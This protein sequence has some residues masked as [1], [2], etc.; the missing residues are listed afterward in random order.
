MNEDMEDLELD[1]EPISFADQLQP[2]DYCRLLQEVTQEHQ[3]HLFTYP[4]GLI[5]RLEDVTPEGVFH[6]DIPLQGMSYT[7]DPETLEPASERDVANSPEVIIVAL[8]F[9]WQDEM[10]QGPRPLWN[11]TPVPTK[12]E[13]EDEAPTGDLPF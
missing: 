1:I 5:V 11:P 3:N 12:S 8:P 9:R 6:F 4:K 10:P 13:D 7:F 2:G